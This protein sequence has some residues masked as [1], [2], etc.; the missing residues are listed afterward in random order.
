MCDS[1]KDLDE[2]DGKEPLQCLIV[3]ACH[4]PAAYISPVN[5]YVC[6]HALAELEFLRGFQN[7]CL[8]FSGLAIVSSF[9]IAI[10]VVRHVLVWEH[11]LTLFH[12]LMQTTRMLVQA[13]I[14]AFLWNVAHR[15]LHGVTALA[16]DKMEPVVLHGFMQTY[17]YLDPGLG[18]C[19][20]C[21]IVVLAE[22]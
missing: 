5:L 14:L 6:K 10:H 13:G 19:G 11:I 12:D 9:C 18:S 7:R 2:S 8:H 21:G 4:L 22:C 1:I 3:S 16:Q 20:Y 17:P 15:C